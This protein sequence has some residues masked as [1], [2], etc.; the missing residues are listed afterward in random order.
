MPTPE[1]RPA[2]ATTPP[3]LTKAPTKAH[4]AAPSPPS[5]DPA[6]G[7]SEAPNR[8]LCARIPLDLHDEVKVLAAR[9]RSSVQAIVTEA[10]RAYLPGRE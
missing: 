4:P 1:R 7:G 9:R 6:Q 10:L 5:V 3:L 2:I 8:M